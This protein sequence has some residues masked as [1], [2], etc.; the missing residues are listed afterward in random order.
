[1][2]VLRL[3]ILLATCVATYGTSSTCGPLSEWAVVAGTTFF[4]DKGPGA[5]M[6]RIKQVRIHKHY[7]VTVYDIALLE[8]EKPITCTPSIQLACLA[9]S[10]V[11][12]SAQN[13]YVAGWGD[14]WV[15]AQVPAEARLKE[16][17]VL[18]IDTQLCN[19]TEWN[20]GRLAPDSV[21]A[22]YPE[23]GTNTCQGD[24]GGPLV[25]KDSKAD[26]YWQVG[27]TSWAFGCARPKK[28]TV[29]M[30]TQYYYNWILEQVPAEPGWANLD[31]AC[32]SAS[33]LAHGSSSWSC[34]LLHQEDMATGMDW[35]CPICHNTQKDVASA[36]P[37]HDQFCLGCILRWAK[38]NP[39]CPLCS[40]P[41]EIVRFSERGEQDYLQFAITAPEELR[42]D[43]SQAGSTHFQLAENSSNDPVVSPMPPSQGTLSA[44]EQGAAGPE[45]MAVLLP[46]VWAELFQRQQQ[47]LDPV[48]P[49][50]RQRLAAIYQHQWWQREAAEGSILHGLCVCGPDAEAL[51]EILEPLLNRHTA[52]LVHGIINVIS[53]QC[54]EEAQ[55]LLCFHHASTASSSSSYTSSQKVTLASGPTGC[56][57]E[58]ETHTSETS[59]QGSPS[60][61]PSMPTCSEQDQPQQEPQQAI[62][63]PGPS[64]QGYSPSA[65]GQGRNHARRKRRTLSSAKQGAAATEAV[66]GLL[67]KVWVELFRNKEHLLDPVLPWLRQ[68]LEAIFGS[69]WWLAVRTE[70]SI[71][72]TFC[73][74][75]PDGEVMVQM[76]QP[77]LEQCTEQLVNGIINI[78]VGQCSE[79]AQRLLHSLAAGEEENS[80]EDSSCSTSP[81]GGNPTWHPTPSSSSAGS[82]RKVQPS[83]SE[84]ALSA[85]QIPH[86][87][88]PIP[89]EQVQHQKEQR[90]AMVASSSSQDCR[91]GPATS[92]QGGEHSLRGPWQLPA[93]KGSSVGGDEEFI[94]WQRYYKR[95]ADEDTEVQESRE[96][97]R[98]L[99]RDYGGFRSYI[100]I[101]PV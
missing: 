19:S 47:L 93:G 1:M 20:M 75:G 84:A 50:L 95:W 14:T 101:S 86:P 30:S 36:L 24:S 45:L 28:P 56:D 7:N 5:Q 64:D 54:S 48:L 12:V 94:K 11:S 4:T 62:A 90:E 22:G 76:L 49:W 71:L 70:H 67:P 57:V 92:C 100:D 35:S 43:S 27:L 73:L 85:P 68:R 82:N 66:G 37:C 81:Q 23:G 15:K 97:M 9:R 91:Q 18:L 55:R 51:V 31:R 88:V 46:E 77:L 52:P 25:C 65:P 32:T 13:C 96:P 34:S 78:I 41:I 42:E 79:E 17:K 60:C 39:G 63:V 61:P 58:E 89:R 99:N 74:C 69:R 40:R 44:A 3:L 53:A 21:C 98:Q 29:F 33:V 8:L 26:I 80:P 10:T 38:T 59:L 83:M 16:A 6:R 72:Y 87:P 2:I